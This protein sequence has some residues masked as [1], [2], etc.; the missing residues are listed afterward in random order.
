MPCF[1]NLVTDHACSISTTRAL[2]LKIH[3]SFLLHYRCHS[4]FI[5]PLWSRNWPN[6]PWQCCLHWNWKCSCELYLW[7]WHIWLLPLWGCQRLVPTWALSYICIVKSNTI[8]M[9]IILTTLLLSVFQWWHQTDWWNWVQWRTC[10][11]LSKRGL[12]HCVWWCM[13]HYRCC[14]GLQTAGILWNK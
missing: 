14:C 2:E 1:I 9:I 6:P 3:F 10:G 12:G 11:G 5:C 8:A 7:Q 4:I 13:G